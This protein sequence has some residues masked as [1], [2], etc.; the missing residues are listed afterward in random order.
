LLIR[1]IKIGLSYIRKRQKQLKWLAV[2]PL[3]FTNGHAGILAFRLF[4]AQ[5]YLVTMVFKSPQTMKDNVLFS[6][7]ANSVLLITIWHYLFKT[8]YVLER[9]QAIVLRQ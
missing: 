8:S 4:K 5:S 6:G 9:T 2:I 3:Q 7:P 1:S